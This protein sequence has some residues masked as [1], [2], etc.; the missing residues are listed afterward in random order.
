MSEVKKQF[1]WQPDRKAL[2]ALVEAA[3]KEAAKELGGPVV[4]SSKFIAGTRDFEM[5]WRL[6][7]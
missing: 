6:A 3:E 4:G 7:G 5:T 2:K 1:K